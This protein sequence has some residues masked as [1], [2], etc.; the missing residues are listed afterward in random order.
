MKALGF[1][2]LVADRRRMSR[3]DDRLIPELTIGAKGY[4]SHNVT[5]FFSAYLE[6]IGIKTEKTAFHS[7][8]H[9]FQD[10]CRHAKMFHGHREAIAGREEGGVGG[11]YG[12]G[13]D[14]ADLNAS[15]QTIRHPSV[16]W[17]AIPAY[18]PKGR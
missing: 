12:D 11:N 7:L 17:S 9:S 3:P 13:Y 15:L 6:K 1:L 16:D 18:R 8:R 10:A 2:F 4:Y 14:L 5:K